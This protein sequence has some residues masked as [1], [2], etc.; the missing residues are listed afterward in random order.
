MVEDAPDKSMHPEQS[1][2]SSLE[3]AGA[4]KFWS[5]DLTND[6]RGRI[7]QFSACR[8]NHPHSDDLKEIKRKA[9]M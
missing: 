2:Q 1:S 3:K 6:S 9:Y 5:H 4:I 7:E 8:I